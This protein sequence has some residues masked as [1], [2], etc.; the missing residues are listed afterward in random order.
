MYLLYGT[1]THTLTL[2]LTLTHLHV[3]KY[4]HTHGRIH[5]S[6]L[7]RSMLVVQGNPSITA[8]TLQ[9]PLILIHQNTPNRNHINVTNRS[10]TAFVHIMHMNGF[11]NRTFAIICH[12]LPNCSLNRIYYIMTVPYYLWGIMF[13]IRTLQLLSLSLITYYFYV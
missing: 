13:V 8:A 11:V 5:P 1:H 10:F 12:S 7:V 9:I 4:V 6:I 2:T 3:P